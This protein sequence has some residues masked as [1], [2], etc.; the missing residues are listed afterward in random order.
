MNIKKKL[1]QEVDKYYESKDKKALMLLGKSERYY[2]SELA[3]AEWNDC[4]DFHGY[5]IVFSDIASKLLEL[6]F[7][8]GHVDR[9]NHFLQILLS[10]Y[11]PYTE[12]TD[13]LSNIQL[14][15]YRE[16]FQV[17]ASLQFFHGLKG[18]A[19]SLTKASEMFMCL[20]NSDK[21]YSKMFNGE[22]LFSDIFYEEISREMLRQSLLGNRDFVVNYFDNKVNIELYKGTSNSRI[23]IIKL[24]Y[25]IAKQNLENGT[26]LA[27]N[28]YLLIR[29]DWVLNINCPECLFP[30]I[31]DM[32]L[33]TTLVNKPFNDNK[34]LSSGDYIRSLEPKI[35]W[36]EAKDIL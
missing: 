33:I 9:M 5:A 6:E 34:N 10:K 15:N 26:K 19:V 23:N 13:T 17:L 3:E 35:I 12:S 28:L 16:Y 18:G 30:N 14:I 2:F 21:D 20:A 7:I 22:L 25:V 27:K 1:E 31:S 36:D 4:T 11:Q 32:H 8:L 24:C 29:L